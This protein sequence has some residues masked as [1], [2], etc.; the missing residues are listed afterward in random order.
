M[1]SRRRLGGSGALRLPGPLARIVSVVDAYDAM[2]GDRPYRKAMSHEEA[3][4]ILCDGTGS[5]WDPEI[6]DA[7]LSALG[8]AGERPPAT[9]ARVSAAG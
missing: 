2:T 5:Q 3:A 6:V 8:D 1:A 4:A 9:P 7:F